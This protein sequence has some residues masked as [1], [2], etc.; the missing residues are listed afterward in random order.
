MAQEV[1]TPSAARLT[2]EMVTPALEATP[3]ADDWTVETI[4]DEEAQ[5]YLIGD[6]SRPYAW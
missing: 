6:G 3:G 4:H 5:V 1:R 2:P